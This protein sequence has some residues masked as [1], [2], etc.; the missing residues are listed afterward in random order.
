MAQKKTAKSNTRTSSRQPAS[1]SGKP[2]TS[3]TPSRTQKSRAQE[4]TEE[5]ESIFALIWSSPWGKML[6][7]LLG[8][9]LLIAI[10]F[11][12]SM[13]HYDKFF[14]ILGVEIVAAMILG[15]IIFLIVERRKNHLSDENDPDM[16]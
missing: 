2:K 7:A 3:G 15:W 5:S 9:L 10:D 11:L 16:Q 13:N 8:I 12:V 14:T 6:Y 4:V 1:R